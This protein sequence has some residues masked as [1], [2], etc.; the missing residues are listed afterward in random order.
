[1]IFNLLGTPQ[2]SDVDM[3]EREDA[4]KYMRCFAKRAG[5]GL[6]SKFPA[7]DDDSIDIMEQ[8][9]RFSPSGRVRVPDA[10]EHRLFAE[11]RDRESETV[12]AEYITLPFELEPDLDDLLL[13]K[14]FC[15]EIR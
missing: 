12:A 13:R 7:P 2:D 6:R 4:K 14:Y 11:L 1:M 9:L 10:L 8:M 5:D 3:L 15:K